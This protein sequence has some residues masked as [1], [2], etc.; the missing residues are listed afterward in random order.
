MPLEITTY[1]VD[2]EYTDHRHPDKVCFTRNIEEDLL[3]RDFTINAMAYHPKL[4]LV[5]PF[6]GQKDLANLMIRA[7]GNAD[8]RFNEDALRIL[9]GL[10]FASSLGFSIDEDTAAAI[11]RQ[12]QLLVGNVKKE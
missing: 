8:R 1:R 3:R 4:G 12:K 6:G 10:R 2:S 11:K 5:D 9:R 7:V